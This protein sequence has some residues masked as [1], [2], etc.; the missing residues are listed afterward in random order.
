MNPL[1]EHQLL[2]TRRQFFGRSGLR[3]GGLA[4]SWLMG[5][6][7]AKAVSPGGPA[8]PG[9]P[10]F[11]HFAPKAKR[12]LYLHMNGAPSQIDMWDH[13]PGLRE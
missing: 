11:P 8:H 13:K 1:I 3:L 9:L 6:D 2:A 7:A 10:G 5:Q 4:L 12:L